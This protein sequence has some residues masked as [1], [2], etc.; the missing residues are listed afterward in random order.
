MIDTSTVSGS[1]GPMSI[2]PLHGVQGCLATKRSQVRRDIPHTQVGQPREPVL[3][4]HTNTSATAISSIAT[5]AATATADAVAIAIAT[6]VPVAS[7]SVTGTGTSNSAAAIITW[8][9]Q[10]GVVQLQTSRDSFKKLCK[11]R[12]PFLPIGWLQ[13][14]F[15]VKAA[16]TSQRGIQHIWTVR[17]ANHHNHPRLDQ[18]AP[19]GLYR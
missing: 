18:A 11:Q 2:A 9:P 7:T 10:S 19:G 6:A 14:R 15:A 17:G 13:L 3:Y 4:L 16:R 5:I 1:G 12:A 8:I